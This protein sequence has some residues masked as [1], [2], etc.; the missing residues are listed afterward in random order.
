MTVQ[1]PSSDAQRA[2]TSFEL[3]EP[4]GE[5]AVTQLLDA[6]SPPS[7]AHV[8]TVAVNAP[9]ADEAL[10]K[11]RETLSRWGDIPV[12]VVDEEPL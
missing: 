8:T 11:V 7:D 10:A 9:S 2:D 1:E 6:L 4:G 3:D 5:Q 12:D